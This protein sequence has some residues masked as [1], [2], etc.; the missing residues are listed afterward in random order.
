MVNQTAIA[1]TF[2]STEGLRIELVLRVE[3][4]RGEANIVQQ[5]IMDGIQGL[6]DTADL[7]AALEDLIASGIQ[8]VAVGPMN[9]PSR[10][11]IETDTVG[12]ECPCGQ[13]D[14]KVVN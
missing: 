8:V 5:V 14:P 7:G 6:I 13:C 12:D 10:Q 3:D 4:E 2:E 9:I 11:D 1:A